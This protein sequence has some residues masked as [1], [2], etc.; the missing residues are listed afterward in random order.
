M[1]VCMLAVEKSTFASGGLFSS[2]TEGQER[3][4]K[5]AE[6]PV[7]GVQVNRNSSEIRGAKL[8]DN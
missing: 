5:V 2:L 7:T 4:L 8:E 6:K 1:F 3:A